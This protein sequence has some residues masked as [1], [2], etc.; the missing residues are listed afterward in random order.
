VARSNIEYRNSAMTVTLRDSGQ[1]IIEKGRGNGG[2]TE[3]EPISIEQ[4]RRLKKSLGAL[5]G[6]RLWIHHAL[7]GHLLVDGSGLGGP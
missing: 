5:S 2:T 7:L 1:F 3:H 6:S 4:S